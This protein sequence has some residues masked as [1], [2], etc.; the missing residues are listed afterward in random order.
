VEEEEPEEEEPEQEEGEGGEA[1][2][3]LAPPA[4]AGAAAAAAAASPATEARR[5]SPA[6]GWWPAKWPVPCDDA[7]FYG[8]I[9]R[10]GEGPSRCKPLTGLNACCYLLGE[11]INTKSRSVAV[12]NR[13][14]VNKQPV[15]LV[16]AEFY[17]NAWNRRCKERNDDSPQDAPV[18]ICEETVRAMLESLTTGS[19][20]YLALHQLLRSIVG[21]L[22][23]VSKVAGGESLTDWLLL[24]GSEEGVA[25]IKRVI[26][27]HLAS[28]CAIPTRTHCLAPGP[29]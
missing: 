1:D 28:A 11:D 16:C 26:A 27:F 25:E 29:E 10:G 17:V 9:T 19:A 2:V 3:E 7:I 8:C 24:P 5:G 20:D 13:A 21:T 6:S 23:A 18:P 22:E 12:G 15:Q 14:R 4:A